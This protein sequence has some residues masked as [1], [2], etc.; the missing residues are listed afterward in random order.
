MKRNIN[1]QELSRDHHHGLLLGWKIRQGLKYAISPEVIAEYVAYFSVAALYPHFREEENYI[2]SYLSDND[3][4][5][6]RTLRE[7]ED[8]TKLIE[9]ISVP[10]VQTETLIKIAQQVDD[11]IRFE[12]RELF[13]YLES[14][15][16]DDQLGKIGDA[17]NS[18]HQPF[19]EDYPLEFWKTV[20]T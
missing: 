6:T 5:K 13:P 1:L 4:F 20:T 11:H 3:E 7:H 2:L 9:L 8:I 18:N 15:L 12:E 10:P 17:I 14:T 16:D 19:V